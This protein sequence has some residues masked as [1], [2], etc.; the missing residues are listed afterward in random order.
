MDWS[1]VLMACGKSRRERFSRVAH[2]PNFCHCFPATSATALELQRM[3][4]KAELQ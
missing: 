2:V 3:L 4:K 1:S